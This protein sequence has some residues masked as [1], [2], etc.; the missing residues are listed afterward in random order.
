MD[1][2]YARNR[3]KLTYSEV[4]FFRR[5]FDAKYLHHYNYNY[6][7]QPRARLGEMHLSVTINNQLNLIAGIIVQ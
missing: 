2:G 7:S 5:R 3:R 1:A 4:F 6:L